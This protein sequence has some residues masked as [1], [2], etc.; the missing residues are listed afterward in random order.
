MAKDKKDKRGLKV[1]KRVAGVKVPKRLRK[2]ANKALAIAE[3]PEAR[4]LAVAALTAAAAA[5]T[6]PRAK[7]AADR[8]RKPGEGGTDDRA[9]K[10]ADSVVAAALEGARRLL[11]GLEAPAAPADRP[12]AAKPK[13]GRA[14]A[15]AAGPGDAADA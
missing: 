15:R 8:P 7:R 10:L 5:L 9:G 2:T 11:D 13:R 6:A 4:E 12:P 3:C 14:S 1:P